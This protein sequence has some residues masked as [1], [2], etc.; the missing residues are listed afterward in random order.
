M[1]TELP[2]RNNHKRFTWTAAADDELLRLKSDPTNTLSMIGLVFGVSK[3][4][5]HT[6]LKRH[7]TQNINNTKATPKEDL[8][9]VIIPIRYHGTQSCLPAIES[10]ISE[11]IPKSITISPA[12]ICQWI[13]R[14]SHYCSEPSAAG[15]SYC[16]EHGKLAFVH[17][18][19]KTKQ[20]VVEESLSE[21]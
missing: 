5:V 12:K 3:Q 14:D 20:P 10:I 11:P 1:S 2:W 15:Y 21:N 16:Q 6:R 7:S 17:F 9:P 19:P 8:P 13:I 18:K 4:T